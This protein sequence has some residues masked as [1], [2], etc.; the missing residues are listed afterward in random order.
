LMLP[1]LTLAANFCGILSGWIATTLAEPISLRLFIERGFKMLSFNDFLPSIAMTAFF[2]L[3][4]GLVASFQGM[5]TTGGTEGVGRSATS[6]VVLCSLFVILA[7]VF[8]VRVSLV[9]FP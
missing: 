3:I 5:R 4:I 6:S 7:D 2:G 9:L 8:L 1:L